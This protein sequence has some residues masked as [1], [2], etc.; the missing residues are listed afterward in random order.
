MPVERGE[1]IRPASRADIPRLS[2]LFREAFGHDRPAE[3]W[4]WKY[5]SNPLGTFSFVCDAGDRIVA[6]C[7]GT[8]IRVVDGSR[9][10]LA[11]Q[12]VDFCASPTYPGGLGAGGVFARTVL[13]FFAKYCGRDASLVY[14]FPGERHRLFGE[15]V[16]G[17]SGIEPVGQLTLEPGPAS[18][19]LSELTEPY[20]ALLS[21]APVAVG[22][23]REPEYV[24]W[25][26]RDHPLHRYSA[27]LVKRWWGK[28]ESIAILRD[29]GE[30]MVLLELEGSY[31]RSILQRMVRQLRALGKPV[32]AWGPLNHPR[33]R[34]LVEAGFRAEERDHRFEARLFVDRPMFSPGEF[35]YS[36]GDYDVY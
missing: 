11:L 22:G 27:L 1:T 20:L 29:A 33:S 3:I 35:Y 21:Q 28:A 34:A 13:A 8:P 17:Y 30:S 19:S 7:G 12:S 6:H 36:L 9:R 26:Y 16:L 23:L 32:V 24:R 14:G 25:R 10:Y 18:G 4:E 31:E 5:F 15:R 2:A